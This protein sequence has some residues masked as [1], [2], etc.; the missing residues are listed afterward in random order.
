M[1]RKKKR[2]HG[3]QNHFVRIVDINIPMYTKD[4]NSA[5]IFLTWICG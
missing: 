4:I 2:N 3:M 5:E 1:N